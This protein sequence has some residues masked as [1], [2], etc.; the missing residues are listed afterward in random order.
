MKETNNNGIAFDNSFTLQ[1]T[2]TTNYLQEVQLFQL[3]NDSSNSFRNVLAFSRASY[4][5]QDQSP[6]QQDGAFQSYELCFFYVNDE[7]DENL[8]SAPTIDDFFFKR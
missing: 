8:L 5:F 2:N 3:G 7:L 6:A 4:Q 1:L